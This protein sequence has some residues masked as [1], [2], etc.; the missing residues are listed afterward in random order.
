MQ[1]REGLWVLHIVVLCSNSTMVI[2]LTYVKVSLILT[3][4][5]IDTLVAFEIFQVLP[6]FYIIIARQNSHCVAYSLVLSVVEFMIFTK[7]KVS[8][9][10]FLSSVRN[11]A[12]HLSPLHYYF[13]HFFKMTLSIAGCW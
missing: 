13:F 4:V 12:S 11:V 9:Q 2:K 1:K 10:A 7:V 3:L 6:D 8:P 5:C